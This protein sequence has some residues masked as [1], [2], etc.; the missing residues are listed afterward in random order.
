MYLWCH[1]IPQTVLTLNLLRTSSLNPK[2]SAWSCLIDPY[3]YNANPIAPLGT[4]VIMHQK[5]GQRATWAPS[6]IDV[7][8]V[9]LVWF[10]LVNL[11]PVYSRGHD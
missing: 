5:P 7:W 4:H 9:G 10:G 6:G 3:D 2:H 11:L 8:Y 1:L